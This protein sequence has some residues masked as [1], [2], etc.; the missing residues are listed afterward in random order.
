M[1]DNGAAPAGEN[2]TVT[3]EA[4]EGYLIHDP[5]TEQQVGPGTRVTL[6]VEDAKRLVRLGCAAIAD[7]G[8][9]APRRGPRT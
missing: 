7:P 3:V 2:D 4:V 9:G 1:A 5:A 6:S 8:P